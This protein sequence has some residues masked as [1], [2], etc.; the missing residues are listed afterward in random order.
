VADVV[1]PIGLLP[2]IDATLTN[3]EGR[4]QRTV[5]AGRLPGEARAGWRVLRALA[6]ELGADGFDFTD[7]DGLRG[8]L[9]AVGAARGAGDASSVPATD[10]G[11]GGDGLALVRTTGIYRSDAV[12]RRSA[13]LQAHPLNVGPR[14]TLHPDDARAA[15]LADGAMARVRTGEGTATLP[16]VASDQVAPGVAWVEGGHGAT[17]AVRGARIQVEAVR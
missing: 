5:A 2:E 14:L 9:A 3:L 17:A 13:A 11:V 1:L 16:V 4:E 15:G 6:G 12:V 8:T 7:L 10:T